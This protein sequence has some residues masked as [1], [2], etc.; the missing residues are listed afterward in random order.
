MSLGVD[1]FDTAEA[2][3]SNFRSVTRGMSAKEV[4]DAMDG[5]VNKAT[6]KV[7]LDSGTKQGAAKQLSSA[8]GGKG[9][10]FEDVEGVA[11]EARF[12]TRFG[13]LYVRQGN[14]QLRLGAY[15]GHGM[16][17]SEPG[18]SIMTAIKEWQKETMSARKQ[19]S[20][21]LAKAIVAAL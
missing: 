6:E 11:D 18:K 16:M 4:S 8:G 10:H 21:E 17:P 7:E 3:S 5:I 19:Q 2:A 15:H 9:L 12:G 1:V 14:L 20:A 13:T